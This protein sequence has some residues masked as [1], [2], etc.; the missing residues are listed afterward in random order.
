MKEI[1]QD[2][3]MASLQAF[4]QTGPRRDFVSFGPILMAFSGMT[5]LWRDPAIERPGSASQT[6]FPDFIAPSYGALAILAALHHRARTGE[7]QYIDISQAETAASMIGPAY[8]EYF[9]NG[10]EPQP[11]GNYVSYAAPH[12]AYRCKGDDRWCAISIAQQEDWLKFC[13]IAGHKEWADRPAFC[14]S[15]RAG[16][17]SR[18]AR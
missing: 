10:R 8:L 3:I 16:C 1:R 2:I 11:L 13:E 14:R 12:G 18:G 15:R 17:Q 9:I 5:Y 4:G 6:A 7:G